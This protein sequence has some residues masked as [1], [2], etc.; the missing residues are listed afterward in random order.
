MIQLNSHYFQPQNTIYL[1]PYPFHFNKFSFH[2]GLFIFI[3]HL[4]RHKLVDKN[5]KVRIHPLACLSIQFINWLS[6][7]TSQVWLK[8]SNTSIDISKTTENFIVTYWDQ[9]TLTPWRLGGFGDFRKKTAVFG[10][11]T[12]ALA[13][14]PIALK[15]CSTAQMD[16]PV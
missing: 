5:G 12:N 15:S 7:K 6:L 1:F 9:D 10:C 2:S 11:L 8:K 13:P 16:Q 3:S 4:F 14:R